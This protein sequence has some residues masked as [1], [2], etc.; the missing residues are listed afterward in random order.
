MINDVKWRE[1]IAWALIGLAGFSV[2]FQLIGLLMGV[3]ASSSSPSPILL[4]GQGVS[5]PMALALVLA[6]LGCLLWGPRTPR[7]HLI[8]FIGA[9]LTFGS[10]VFALAQ[11]A[12]RAGQMS[13]YSDSTGSVLL[14]TFMGSL[15]PILLG[16]VMILL[17]RTPDS[18][19]PS[20]AVAPQPQLGQQPAGQSSATT[21]QPDQASGA[22]WTTASG[23]AAGGQATNYGVPG[24]NG[25][26]NPAP[27]QPQNQQY[28]QIEQPYQQANQWGDPRQQ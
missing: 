18:N 5:A 27:Q 25:G 26:W 1:P 21:W 9:G 22:A 3:A 16:V 20:A 7:A 19:A 8:G 6:L 4:G 12:I 2:L 13:R 17:A 14:S 23:A 24:Q 11:S 28:Q 15:L 10:V